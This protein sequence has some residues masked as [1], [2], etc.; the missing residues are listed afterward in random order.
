MDGFVL[1][2]CKR[3]WLCRDADT[4]R[5]GPGSGSGR[6]KSGYAQRNRVPPVGVFLDRV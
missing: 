3:P 2:G 5:S 1:C 6:R 4:V